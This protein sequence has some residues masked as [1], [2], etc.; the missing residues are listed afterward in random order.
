MDNLNI[1]MLYLIINLASCFFWKS[2]LA[3]VCT[4]VWPHSTLLKHFHWMSIRPFTLKSQSTHLQAGSLGL[5]VSQERKDFK[6]LIKSFNFRRASSKTLRTNAH[7]I[8]Q[9]KMFTFLHGGQLV[10]KAFHTEC[11]RWEWILLIC[12][13]AGHFAVS[14]T[15]C[16]TP[17]AYSYS[18]GFLLFILLLKILGGLSVVMC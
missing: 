3:S 7:M 18:F 4:C 16:S 12:K 13:A 2:F 8:T 15:H 11:L 5:S 10:S 6:L 14:S 9:V 1:L 17:G